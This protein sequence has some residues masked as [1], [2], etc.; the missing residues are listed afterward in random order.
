M[1]ACSSQA[2]ILEGRDYI[3]YRSPIKPDIPKGHVQVLQFF[4]YRCSHCL[5]LEKYVKYWHAGQDERVTIE[6]VPVIFKAEDLAFAQVFYANR[7]LDIENFGH[8][9]LFRA[10][11]KTL[12]ERKVLDPA[13]F[14]A[15]I[16][17]FEQKIVERAMNNLLTRSHVLGARQN[18]KQFGVS[19]VPAFV[20]NGKYYTDPSMAGSYGRAVNI[21]DYLVNKELR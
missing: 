6:R 21:V 5:E 15:L 12:K 2:A 13:K 8:K 11:L 19:G 7:E 14:I 1:L 9:Y 18:A 10:N 16:S 17:G 20:I 3:K 4:S